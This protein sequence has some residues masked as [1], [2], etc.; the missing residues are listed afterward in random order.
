MKSAEEEKGQPNA[1]EVVKPARGKRWFVLF[2]VSSILAV[3]FFLLYLSERKLRMDLTRDLEARQEQVSELERQ[4]TELT[5]AKKDA[6]EMLNTHIETLDGTI[7]DL[8]EKLA[9]ASKD[10]KSLEEA[11]TERESQVDELI[12]AKAA[13]ERESLKKDETLKVLEAKTAKSESP[14]PKKA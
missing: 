1:P 14:K 5:G 2:I 11:L 6:E 7:R 10:R 13:L 4:V 8:N 9:A 3:T 12:S